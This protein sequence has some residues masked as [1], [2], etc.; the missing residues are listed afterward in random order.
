MTEEQVNLALSMG[1]ILLGVV[2]GFLL[3]VWNSNRIESK[4]RRQEALEYHFNDI[5]TNIMQKISV[6]ARSL[7]INNNRLVFGGIDSIKEIYDFEKEEEYKGFEIHFP[8]IA[9]EWIRL[10]GEAIKASKNTENDIIK[11][12][13]EFR[14]Y[15][16]RLA[17]TIRDI[18]K[19]GIGT[20]FKHN[21]KCP[22]CKKF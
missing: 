20:V 22:I 16:S 13:E 11:L 4:R 15:D 7:C 18:Q 8:E 10:K 3:N 14:E 17:T 12:Q 1:G 6:R 21:E 9:S 5:H 2:V 19:Y